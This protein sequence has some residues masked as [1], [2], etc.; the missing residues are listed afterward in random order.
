MDPVDRRIAP[1]GAS[2]SSGQD[3]P[4]PGTPAL[5]AIR[6][7]PD[8]G[9]TI[10]AP[11][12]LTAVPAII[13]PFRISLDPLRYGPGKGW[14]EFDSIPGQLY[15]VQRSTNMETWQIIPDGAISAPRKSVQ[16]VDGP[17]ADGPD[18]YFC[19]VQVN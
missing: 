6:V 3:L 11:A 16:L 12:T 17:P 15:R 7:N 5:P 10:L 19:R 1:G 14:L 4:V 8:H 13:L 2:G 9:R 18:H